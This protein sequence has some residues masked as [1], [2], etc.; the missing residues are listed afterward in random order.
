MFVPSKPKT[1]DLTCVNIIGRFY[2]PV[3]WY[4]AQPLTFLIVAYVI[5]SGEKKKKDIG[6]RF[7]FS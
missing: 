6:H 7:L 4:N 2:R 3:Q 1:Y 5:I